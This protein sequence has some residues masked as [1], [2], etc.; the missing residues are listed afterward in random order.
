MNEKPLTKSDISVTKALKNLG[1]SGKQ[2][3]IIKAMYNK[4]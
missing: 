1:I 3:N 4:P 2:L